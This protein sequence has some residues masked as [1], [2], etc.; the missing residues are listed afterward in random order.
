V[1]ELEAFPLLKWPVFR[2]FCVYSFCNEAIA[3]NGRLVYLIPILTAFC[4]VRPTGYYRA[5]SP[6]DFENPSKFKQVSALSLSDCDQMPIS[7]LAKFLMQ[8]SY[9]Q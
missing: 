1:N 6:P 2:G 3:L 4:S 8:Q 9:G 5:E 7:Y